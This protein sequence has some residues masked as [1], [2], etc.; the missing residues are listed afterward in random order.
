MI[1]SHLDDARDIDRCWLAHIK[2]F[3]NVLCF[4]DK[5]NRVIKMELLISCCYSLCGSVICNLTNTNVEKCWAG[6]CKYLPV[7]VSSYVEVCLCLLCSV[8][9]N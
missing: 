8:C 4:F 3:N 7:S 9:I 5:L 1:S 2:Q 6:I